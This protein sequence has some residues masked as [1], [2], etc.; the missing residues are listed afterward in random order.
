MAVDLERLAHGFDQAFRHAAHIF[1]LAD[2]G[3]HDGEFVAAQAGQRVLLA[4]VL[5][6]ALGQ[7]A[8]QLVAKCVAQRVVHALE[9]VQVQA[10]HRG[11][12]VATAA[13]Q[14]L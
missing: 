3:Q 10:Q 4:Q 2:V 11:R 13:V 7:Q 1:L 5:G 12:A 14:R 6:Q 9:V 8:Q